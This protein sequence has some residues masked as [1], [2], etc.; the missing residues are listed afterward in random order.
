M[1]TIPY[2]LEAIYRISKLYQEELK[3][4]LE[5]FYERLMWKKV[6]DL[7]DPAEQAR[8][9]YEL[10]IKV[11]LKPENNFKPIETRDSLKGLVFAVSLMN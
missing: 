5:S 3:Y 1:T 2:H 8:L 9:G 7:S 4:N 10:V 11:F 6:E